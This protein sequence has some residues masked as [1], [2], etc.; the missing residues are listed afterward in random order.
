MNI[1]KQNIDALNATLKIQL[2][3]EDY[4]ER[5]EKV[6]SDY[7]RK[8]N[9]PGF[10][11]GKVPAG[12][13]KKMY[14]KAV[15]ADEINKLVS[16]KINEYIKN[17]DIHVLGDPL[18]NETEN[19]TV[20][21]DT[22]TDFE[23][24][25]DLGLSPAI[26][27]KLSAKDKIT[28]YEIKADET[29]INNYIISYTRRYGRFVICNAVEADE[30]VKGDLAEVDEKG[31]LVEGGIHSENASIYLELAKDEAEKDAFKGAKVGDVVKFDIKKAFPNDFEI[32]NLLK[33][34]KEKVA[35]AASHYQ[36]TI[37]E[38]SRFEQAEMNT[39]L[40]DKVYGEGTV[41]T[42][43]DFRKKITDEISENL[44]KDSDY[45][46]L[47]D[48]KA[49]FLKKLK[50]EL[51]AAFMK[52]WLAFINEGKLTSEQIEK[53]YPAFEEDMK[54]QL[55]KNQFAKENNIEVKEDEVVNQAKEATLMQ[56]RQ[57]GI[58]NLPD[59][60]LQMYAVNLLKK[61]NEVR[62]LVEK[63]MESKILS[64]IKEN[65]TLDTKQ[66]SN[67]EFGKLFA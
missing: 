53:D 51:P 39:E 48:T 4:Q 34:E 62:R 5:V 67:E 23:F 10:R 56:F 26:D 21:F 52:R 36:M 57:Y 66:I 59:E 47:L 33:I 24:V 45:K 42:E 16:E 8:A 63:V 31:H 14:G 43:V 38:V 49:Y 58:N 27:V 1:S 3:K 65:V 61:E 37:S 35:E 13:I 29:M 46:F 30:M 64:F 25:F 20:D 54:W 9:M 55:I 11:P 18:P 12:L 44:K 50:L 6:L 60:Q 22:D 28:N 15:L 7:R 32:S 40:F 17:E 19:K 2:G 41:A